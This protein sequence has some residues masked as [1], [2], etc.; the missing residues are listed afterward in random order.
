M[1]A[2][3]RLTSSFIVFYWQRN[4]LPK[5]LAEEEKKVA[6]LLAQV[7]TSVTGK[8]LDLGVDTVDKC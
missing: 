2:E 8:Q 5:L 1:M 4:L 6:M 3:R 7:G